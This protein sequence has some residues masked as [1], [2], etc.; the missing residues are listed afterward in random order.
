ARNNLGLAL[1]GKGR[2][3]DAIPQSQ[4]AIALRPAMTQAHFNLGRSLKG[5]Q[6]WTEAAAALGDA[7]AADPR[8]AEGWYELA[9][10]QERLDD[11]SASVRSCERALECRADFPE[12]LVALGD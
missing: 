10:V 7:V 3:E 6:R 8:Y 9:T 4:A 1:L 5:L 12:A 11:S 2:F